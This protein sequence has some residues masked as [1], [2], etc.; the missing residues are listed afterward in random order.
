[1]EHHLQ[2]QLLRFSGLRVCLAFGV[3]KWLLLKNR[4]VK[5]QVFRDMTCVQLV[6][7]LKEQDSRT[8]LKN[9]YNGTRIMSIST[10]TRI[11]KWETHS[12][13]SPKAERNSITI[14]EIWKTYPNQSRIEKRGENLSYQE[15]EIGEPT[16]TS[17]QTKDK[18]YNNQNSKIITKILIIVHLQSTV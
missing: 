5:V 18:I 10:I 15:K 2:R 1:M 13:L 4:V 3:S 16:L 17:A 11:G 9:S 14:Q 6:P 12:N 7:N 8:N